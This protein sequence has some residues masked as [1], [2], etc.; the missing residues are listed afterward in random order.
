M[1]TRTIG[2]DEMKCAMELTLQVGI[3]REYIALGISLSIVVQE[4]TLQYINL[5]YRFMSNIVR[6]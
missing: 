6:M 2:S 3:P 4:F 5:K 1:V